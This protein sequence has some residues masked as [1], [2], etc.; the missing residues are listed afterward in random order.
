MPTFLTIVLLVLLAG[1][2]VLS[3][4]GRT[5]GSGSGGGQGGKGVVS[6]SGCSPRILTGDRAEVTQRLQE[7]SLAPAP[8]DLARGAMCYKVAM[9][10]ER[11]EY[12]CPTCGEKTLYAK[13]D[14][15]RTKNIKDL[16]WT[17]HRDLDLCRRIVR[18]IRKISVK[19]DESQFCRK[20]KPDVEAPQLELVVTYEE[21]VEPH[22]AKGVRPDDLLL[23][24][25]FVE[26]KTKHTCST[27]RQTPM[28]NHVKRLADLLGI[29]ME[30]TKKKPK[31]INVINAMCYDMGE[32]L[33][34]I[35]Y[36]CPSCGEKTLFPLGH[37]GACSCG[38]C[39]TPA[40]NKS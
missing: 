21:D 25:D 7:L 39:G 3:G 6:E 34:R 20:C 17:L 10:S 4:C 33:R 35:D 31:K 32:L 36:V 40:E 29:D 11:H 26:G 1:L 28:K 18:E 15:D 5:G 22:R 30:Q 19:L 13:D 38:S 2:L 37:D 14:G 8:T 16:A 9:P 23:I 27:D 12:I 24:K